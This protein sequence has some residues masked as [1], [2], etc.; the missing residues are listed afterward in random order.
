MLSANFS[1]KHYRPE[2]SGVIYLKYKGKN[3]QPRIL[4]PARLSFKIEDLDKEL[5]QRSKS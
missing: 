5:P 4:Y 1:Q 3:L 2:R